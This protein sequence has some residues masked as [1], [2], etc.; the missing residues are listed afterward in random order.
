MKDKEL[1]RSLYCTLG[2]SIHANVNVGWAIE[3][4][5]PHALNL[6]HPTLKTKHAAVVLTNQLIPA[7]IPTPQ[8]L[9]TH[10]N[11][12]DKDCLLDRHAPAIQEV[13]QRPSAFLHPHSR[14]IMRESA[15]RAD[16]A[17]AMLSCYLN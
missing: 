17:Q 11:P 1:Y 14:S 15:V 4:Y 16:L 7:T 2:P 8:A 9:P 12:R 13:V 5:V 3:E 6:F 10:K